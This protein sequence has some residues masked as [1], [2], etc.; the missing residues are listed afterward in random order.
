VRTEFFAPAF[1]PLSLIRSSTSDTTPELCDLIV[2]EFD[3]ACEES[4][5]MRLYPIFISDP[6]SNPLHLLMGHVLQINIRTVQEFSDP[7]FYLTSEFPT[8]SL[9]L[10]VLCIQK[11]IISL[12]EATE[13]FSVEPGFLT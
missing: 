1:P 10:L 11:V 3:L 9:R 8:L 5:L 6:S 7:F 13:L 12:Q 4:Y 2:K